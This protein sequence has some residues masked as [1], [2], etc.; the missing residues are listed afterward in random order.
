MPINVY[1]DKTN[2]P[3]N[4]RESDETVLVEAMAE[5]TTASNGN[6]TF[7]VV[8][9][10]I[11]PCINIKWVKDSPLGQADAAGIAKL[12]SVTLS[13]KNYIQDVQIELATT[14]LSGLPYTNVGMKIS[15]LHE[16]GHAL[17]LWGHSNDPNDLMYPTGP[18][19]GDSISANDALTLNAL[20]ARNADVPEVPA[21]TRARVPSSEYVI[22]G[23]N[24]E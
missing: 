16:L 12:D 24:R 18:A 21:G 23:R 11:I 7:N 5:W 19:S 1:I 3:Q 17:G 13:G 6:I 10:P 8:S 22:P 15:S 20:Y 9:S 4:W 14:S 2:L